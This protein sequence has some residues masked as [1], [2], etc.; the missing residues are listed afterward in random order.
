MGDLILSLRKAL[1][2]SQ[3]QQKLEYGSPPPAWTSSLPGKLG[4]SST[5]RPSLFLWQSMDMRESNFWTKSLKKCLPVL[6]TFAK[7]ALL[8]A[9]RKE[10]CAFKCT[11]SFWAVVWNSPHCT[12]HSIMVLHSHKTTHPP[13]L[14]TVCKLHHACQQLSFL[15]LKISHECHQTF[16]CLCPLG[17]DPTLCKHHIQTLLPPPRRVWRAGGNT[18]WWHGGLCGLPSGTSL[19]KSCVD[20][21]ALAVPNHYHIFKAEEC[22]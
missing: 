15:M 9:N 11:F 18:G 5:I 3:A 12:I 14:S 13:N 22:I 6:I 1:G 16:F 10:G 4:P 21:Q 8:F 2:V 7:D 20:T 17:V 19:G